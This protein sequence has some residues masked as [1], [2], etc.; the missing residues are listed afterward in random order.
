[1]NLWRNFI[2]ASTRWKIMAFPVTV[3][4]RFGFVVWLIC[5]VTGKPAERT[6]NRL[7]KNVSCSTVNPVN[8]RVTRSHI[9]GNFYRIPPLSYP[10]ALRTPPRV[11]LPARF[12]FVARPVPGR[13][14]DL[15]KLLIDT[16]DN[17]SPYYTPA[18]PPSSDWQ[19]RVS[20]RY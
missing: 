18:L 8:V 4:V 17:G 3:G 6:A 7:W 10:C 13:S 16:G 14:D 19:D 5:R 1:M 2:P 12:V 20:T 15:F 11:L 9:T